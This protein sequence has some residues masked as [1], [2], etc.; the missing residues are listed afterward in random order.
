MKKMFPVYDPLEHA[1][2]L[3]LTLRVGELSSDDH[4]AEFNL[5]DWSIT[6]KRG[7]SMIDDR[8][9]IAH[10]IVHAEHRDMPIPDGPRRWKREARCNRVAA[11]RLV[12]HEQLLELAR[13]IEDPGVWCDELAITPTLLVAYIQSHPLPTHR[14]E[15]VH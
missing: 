2:Q 4:L 9:A 15:L 3:G 12:D 5:F 13:T 8:C 10:D 11:E 14:L 7:L 6:R 1:M